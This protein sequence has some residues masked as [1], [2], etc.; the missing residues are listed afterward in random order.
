MVTG[1]QESSQRTGRLG[2]KRPSTDPKR[3]VRKEAGQDRDV[4]LRISTFQ[5]LREEEN[6]T[7]TD[8]W[9]NWKYQ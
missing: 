2:R 5:F 8:T 7:R 9:S 4:A 3:D 1:S 6:W